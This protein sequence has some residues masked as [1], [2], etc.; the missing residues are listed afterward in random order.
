MTSKTWRQRWLEPLARLLRGETTPRR[1]A[2]RRPRVV[3]LLEQ[4]ETRLAP[5]ATFSIANNSVIEPA[6]NGSRANLGELVFKS[7]RQTVGH[8]EENRYPNERG[9]KCECETARVKPPQDHIQKYGRGG[10]RDK[11]TER[12]HE[13]I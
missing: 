6:P 11:Q 10:K 2:A 13:Y 1:H 4:L 8:I 9:T 7:V 3:P 12:L 5:A